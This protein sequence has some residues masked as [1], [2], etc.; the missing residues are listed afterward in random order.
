MATLR[1]WSAAAAARPH[2]C[3]ALFD[4]ECLRRSPPKRW[5][6]ANVVERRRWSASGGASEG[7]DAQ[8]SASSTVSRR[9]IDACDDGHSE[10]A[11]LRGA[12]RGSSS[13]ISTMLNEVVAPAPRHVDNF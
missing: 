8:F 10:A 9:A 7:A 12:G 3:R 11:R 13:T 1:C 5:S 2:F 4:V 6:A